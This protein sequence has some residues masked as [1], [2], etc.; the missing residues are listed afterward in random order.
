[1]GID[2][3]ISEKGGI[4]IDPIRTSEACQKRLRRVSIH[5]Y[6]RWTPFVGSVLESLR[7]KV[8]NDTTV[9]GFVGLPFT[10]GSYLIEGTT[11][12]STDFAIT[13]ELMKSQPEL[14]HEILTCLT[15]NIGAYACYQI[16]SGAQ[17]IQV[18]D[19][20]AGHVDDEDYD[21][22]VLYYQQRVIAQIKQVSPETPVIIYMA[23]GP[24]SKHGKRLLKLAESGADVI[25]IDH[26]M[27]IAQACQVLPP[28]L[29]IQGNLDPQVLRDGPLVKIKEKVFE[30]LRC[31]EGRSHIMNLGHGILADTPEENAAF[32]VKLVQDYRYPKLVQDYRYPKTCA[33]PCHTGIDLS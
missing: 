2:F 31:V 25:S 24:C 3:A 12:V 21:Q 17:V 19:S 26:T 20:W 28:H 30:I 10:L 8:P 22:F 29:G 9:L 18:F 16:E 4:H 23:P 32:F 14:V 6:Q 33:E 5:D 13:K 11:G 15:L 27:D 7:E 1:M